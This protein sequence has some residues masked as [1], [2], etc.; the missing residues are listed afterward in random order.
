MNDATEVAEMECKSTRI[1]IV[2]DL[3]YAPEE[4]LDE[5]TRRGRKLMQYARPLLERLVVEANESLRPDLV[6]NLGDLVQDYG[7]RSADVAAM[8]FIWRGFDGLAA[9]HATCVGNHDLRATRNR[10]ET[11]RALGC[12]DSTYSFDA[13]GLHVI[14]L[15]TDV[16]YEAQTADG[17]RF[18]QHRLSDEDLTWLERDLSETEL[19]VVVCLHFGLAEDLQEGNYWFGS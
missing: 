11:A 8:Q 16:N 13:A 1:L 5:E 15:G 3:H 6:V 17:I 18:E 7:N 4:W 2:S 19:P 9:P 12:E 14:V 10:R